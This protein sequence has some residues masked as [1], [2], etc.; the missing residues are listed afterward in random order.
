MDAILFLPTY[1]QPDKLGGEIYGT[2]QFKL[3]T[4]TRV[5]L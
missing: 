4:C 1:Q 2:A 5:L 3:D